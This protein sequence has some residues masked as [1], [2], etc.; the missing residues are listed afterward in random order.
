[1]TT[2]VRRGRSAPAGGRRLLATIRNR[3]AALPP[4]K[5][6][7]HLHVL[8][9]AGAEDVIVRRI[10]ATSDAVRE[11]DRLASTIG[12]IEAALELRAAEMLP[13]GP[14]PPLTEAEKAALRSGGMDLRPRD[15]GEP[16]PIL[17]GATQY[18]RLI[19]ESLTVREAAAR[20]GGVNES[21]VRQRLLAD[22]P[23]LYAVKV[24]RAWRLP[25]FQ[26]LRRGALPGLGAVL[27]ALSPDLDG[28][29]VERWFATPNADLA[30]GADGQP[31]SPADWLRMGRSSQRAAEL[32]REL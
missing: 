13:A 20:L 27:A 5:V 26:F 29:E 18:A 4:G 3:L 30:A 31:V 6:G 9:V 23:T 1:M 32:A 25:R 14:S 15:A 28:V 12:A 11:A 22:P 19:N 7:G 8:I 17:E 10:P 21:R 24:G 2:K 16:D